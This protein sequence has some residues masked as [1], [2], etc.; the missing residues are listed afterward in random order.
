MKVVAVKAEKIKARGGTQE[1]EKAV[2]QE[3][4]DAELREERAVAKLAHGGRKKRGETAEVGRGGVVAVA[5]A[6]KA[7]EGATSIAAKRREVGAATS[8]SRRN[9]HKHWRRDGEGAG[10]RR[11]RRTGG[12][13]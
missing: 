3:S 4:Q 5:R 9:K 7:G 2:N 11:L 8:I 1:T 10:D 13:G 12:G 6:E